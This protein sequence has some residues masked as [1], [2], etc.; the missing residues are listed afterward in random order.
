LNYLLRIDMNDQ[1]E[2]KI[3][4]VTGRRPGDRR[5]MEQNGL[6]MAKFFM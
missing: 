6:E 3:A 5:K 1:F 2:A 4:L